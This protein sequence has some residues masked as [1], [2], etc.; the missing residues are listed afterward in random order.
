MSACCLP[1][2]HY[3]AEEFLADA[4]REG[5]R[6]ALREQQLSLLFPR[7]MPPARRAE[8]RLVALSFGEA[9]E[10]ALRGDS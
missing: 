9:L 7:R 4:E 5:V 6:F 3:S 1:I 8:I 2:A 10:R